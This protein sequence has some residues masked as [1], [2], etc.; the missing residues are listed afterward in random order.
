MWRK[1]VSGAGEERFQSDKRRVKAIM[2][3]QVIDR[4]ATNRKPL[5]CS[6]TKKG[7]IVGTQFSVRALFKGGV[8]KVTA[9]LQASRLHLL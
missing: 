8:F 4:V 6:T 3:L 2:R 5:R 1:M 7:G 9:N